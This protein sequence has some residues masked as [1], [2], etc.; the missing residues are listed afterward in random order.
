VFADGPVRGET[1]LVAGVLGAVASLAAQ[2]AR[3]DGRPS[4]APSGAAMTSRA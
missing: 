2:L 3:R 1:V 4:S